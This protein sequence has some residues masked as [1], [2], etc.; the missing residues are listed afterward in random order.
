MKPQNIPPACPVPA[1]LLFPRLQ[2]SAWVLLLRVQLALACGFLEARHAPR[3]LICLAAGL[4]NVC[5][6][7][8]QT[9]RPFSAHRHRSITRILCAGATPQGKRG[10]AAR[11]PVRK[12]WRT[13]DSQAP[14]A[15]KGYVNG[16]VW[17]LLLCTGNGYLTLKPFRLLGEALCTDRSTHLFHA[18]RT[19]AEFG[20]MFISTCLFRKNVSWSAA[21]LYITH[22][23]LP[24]NLLCIYFGIYVYCTT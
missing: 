6:V 19:L 22:N 3:L 4:T 2:V 20:C 17:V 14:V 16:G 9:H 8:I 7:G 21:R 12:S 5:C 13:C 23:E 1:A 10:V 18:V 11:P 15:K 24:G